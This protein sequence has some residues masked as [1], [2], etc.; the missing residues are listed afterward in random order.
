M[1]CQTFSTG[2]SSGHFG[3]SSMMVML[4][5]TTRR[6]DMC[7]PAGSCKR[8]AWAAGATDNEQRLDQH[9]HI[10]DV[11]DELFDA[12]LKLN[13]PHHTHLKPEVA[14]GGTQVVLDGNGL[15]LKQFAM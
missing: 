15:R 8:M 1:N 9:S 6:G 11:L 3:G 4:A 10:G 12:P 5:V 14:Q 2:L 7:Q 13:R